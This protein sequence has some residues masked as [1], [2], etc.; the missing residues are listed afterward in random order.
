MPKTRQ[1][2]CFVVLVET[3]FSSHPPAKPFQHHLPPIRASRKKTY[4]VTS[5]SDAGH[6]GV[7]SD[8]LIFPQHHLPT[9]LPQLAQNLAPGGRGLPQSVQ[10][11]ALA[12]IFSPHDKQ[13]FEPAGTAVPHLGHTI[14]PS[15]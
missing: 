7:V 11:E 4:T 15:P 9:G 3:V 8:P 10:K 5:A 13:N 2:Y 14:W 6:H 1:Y 12:S